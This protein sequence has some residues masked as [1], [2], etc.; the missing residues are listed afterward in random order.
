R[1]AGE[2][3]HRSAER[4][5]NILGINNRLGFSVVPALTL[6][7]QGCGQRPMGVDAVIDAAPVPRLAAQAAEHEPDDA[8]SIYPADRSGELLMDL[9]A[10]SRSGRSRLDVAKSP[11]RHPA[12]EPEEPAILPPSTSPPLHRRVD[13][14]KKSARPQQLADSSPLHDQFALP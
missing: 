5:M 2:A 6:L 11:Q 10:P 9:L 14:R 13:N 3:H 12:R 1:R 4:K 8:K 7:V